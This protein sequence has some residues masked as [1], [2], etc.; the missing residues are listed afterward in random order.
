[1]TNMTDRI[2]D[3][4][5]DALTRFPSTDTTCEDAIFALFRWARLLA[6]TLPADKREA[7][8]CR[9]YQIAD[10]LAAPEDE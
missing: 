9:A 3:A 8:A 1:M 2:E 4:I 5:G 7:W 6:D 10:H